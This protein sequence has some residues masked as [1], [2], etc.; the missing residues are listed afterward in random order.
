MKK[1]RHREVKAFPSYLLIKWWDSKWIWIPVIWLKGNLN[2]LCPSPQIHKSLFWCRE[3]GVKS[4]S[5]S[6]STWIKAWNRCLSFLQLPPGRCNKLHK[7]GSKGL[8]QWFSTR[9]GFYPPHSILGINGNV[10]DTSD[11]HNLGKRYWDLVDRGSGSWESISSNKLDVVAEH[12]Q[13]WTQKR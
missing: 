6:W 12:K 13:E 3:S 9:N 4:A 10:R 2:L 5:I 1:L 8:T 7:A 11:C